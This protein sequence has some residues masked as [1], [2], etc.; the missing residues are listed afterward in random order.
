MNFDLADKTLFALQSPCEPSCLPKTPLPRSI[1]LQSSEQQMP[2]GKTGFPICQVGII[3]E[4]LTIMP[5]LIYGCPAAGNGFIAVGST[6]DYKLPPAIDYKEEN[7]YSIAMFHQLHCLV[8]DRSG[9][10]NVSVNIRFQYTIM[11]TYNEFTGGSARSRATP[12]HDIHPNHNHI[13][14]CFRYLRQSI[15][16]C[17]DV[18]L[19]GQDPN[20]RDPATD[21]SGAIHVC[22]NFDD[23]RNW[24]EERRLTN[25]KHL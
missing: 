18:A 24:A 21:G 10:L 22:K 14:H 13:D 7:A 4:N 19:E 23:I 8:R 11:S 5:E 25:S 2:R 1:I 12:E 15:L 6:S 9:R 16:C 20:S 17:G 3:V